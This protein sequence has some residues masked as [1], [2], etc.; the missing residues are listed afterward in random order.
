M[1]AKS[2]YYKELFIILSGSPPKKFI[3]EITVQL[4]LYRLYGI[5]GSSTN[6]GYAMSKGAIQSLTKSLAVE[7]VPRKIMVNSIAPGFVKTEMGDKIN[8]S[9]DLAHDSYI[10]HLHLL[11]YG[12]PDDIAA[13]IAFCFLICQNG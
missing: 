4:S 10:D 13:G 3:P 5:V 12:T 11:G 7:L 6:S 2:L 1:K 9:F 8:H